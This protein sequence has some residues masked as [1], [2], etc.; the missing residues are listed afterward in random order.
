HECFVEVEGIR[1]GSIPSLAKALGLS[2][3]AIARRLKVFGVQPMVGKD[4]Q[5]HQCNFYPEHIAREKCADLLAP[6]PKAGPNGL[7]EIDGVSYGTLSTFTGLLGLSITAI[8]VRIQSS[9]VKPIQGKDSNDHLADLYPELALRKLCKDLIEAPKVGPDGFIKIDGVLHGTRL[10]LARF[11][12]LV[13]K[14]VSERLASSGLGPVRGRGCN[15][16]LTDLYP[17]PAAREACK[18]LLVSAK[19]GSTSG[20]KKSKK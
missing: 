1:Y 12:G 20:G 3:P 13:E 18:D 17:E 4:I 6:L 5:N 10:S 9:G 16:K 19:G 2:E 15:G 7:I 8:K 14:T 11:L